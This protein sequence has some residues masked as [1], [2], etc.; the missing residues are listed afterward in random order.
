MHV[1]LDAGANPN[2]HTQDGSTPLMDAVTPPD[3]ES[4]EAWRHA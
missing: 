2:E 3:Y 4:W 1:L